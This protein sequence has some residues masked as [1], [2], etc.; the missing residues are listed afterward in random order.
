MEYENNDLVPGMFQHSDDHPIE[1]ADSAQAQP[2]EVQPAEIQP[3]EAKPAEPTLVTS[4]A[5]AQQQEPAAMEAGSTLARPQVARPA[6]AAPVAPTYA[7][8]A[9]QGQYQSYGYQ[10]PQPYTP[11]ASAPAPAAATVRT[12]TVGRGRSMLWGLIGGVLGAAAVMCG[13]YFTGI[14][15][16]ASDG[17][18]VAQQSGQSFTIT[19]SDTD[20]SVSKAVAAK[21]LPS[22]VTVSCTFANGTG[23]GSGVI[24]DTEGNIITN[25]HVVDGAESITVTIEGITY[26][27]YIVGTDASSDLAVI[28][29]E[30]DDA[31][32]TPIEVG[33]SS[34]LSP[35]D[36]VMTVG[37]PF[38]LDSSVSSG[39]VSSLYRSELMYG[40]TGNTLYA[41]L[42][43]VD[44][45]INPGNSGGALVNEQG[46]LVGICT[47]FSS[48]TQSFAGIG[49]AIPGNY[50]V[51]IAQ[52]IIN[53]EQ[54]THAYIGLSMMTVNAQNAAANNLS[55]NYGAYVA[56]VADGGPAEAAGL[57]VGD[58]AISIGGERIESAD[59]AVLAIRTHSIGET[60]TV[61]VMRGDEKL[62]FEVTLGSDE[63]LQELQAQQREQQQTEQEQQQNYWYND[64]TYGNG[65]GEGITYEDLYNQWLEELFGEQGQ[66]YGYPNGNGRP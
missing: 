31:L 15:N 27:A 42:I 21:T 29:A 19:A 28:R 40:E 8:N 12:K 49:F 11:T 6:T 33:D 55:S 51:E 58:I 52:M 64:D 59:A 26:D 9:Y 44:A 13:L 24:L 50:A 20:I 54:V 61:T 25:N 34:A 7:N 57:E 17:S 63:R 4:A 45:A 53:G 62:D 56:E 38:G 60:V 41:N 43:Q 23:T 65:D 47:L 66:E 1:Q 16:P 48:D 14:L 37:S 35:G 3:T 36:W 2:A 39:I 18:V 5:P 46:Q 32:L 22:V 10:A 30:A